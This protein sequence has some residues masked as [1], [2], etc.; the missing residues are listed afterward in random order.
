MM[1]RMRLN[2]MKNWLS[3]HDWPAKKPYISPVSVMVSAYMPAVD[4]TRTHYQ[5]FESE[6]SQFLR[7]VSVDEWAKSTRTRPMKMKTVAPRGK[8]TVRGEPGDEDE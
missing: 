5:R 3:V 4:P 2:V 1:Q 8:E 7:Q 6:F